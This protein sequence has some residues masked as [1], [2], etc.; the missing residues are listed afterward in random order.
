MYNDM[1]YRSGLNLNEFF[2]NSANLGV[3][4]LF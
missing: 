2:N 1:D 3:Y 4:G